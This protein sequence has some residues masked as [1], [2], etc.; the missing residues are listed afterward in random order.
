VH[1]DKAM[2]PFDKTDKRINDKDRVG[3]SKDSL[4]NVYVSHLLDVKG[5]TIN[6][7]FAFDKAKNL[8]TYQVTWMPDSSPAQ[9]Y[10]LDENG[11][12]V[13]WD[14]TQHLT[15]SEKKKMQKPVD[16]WLAQYK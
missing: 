13:D 14:A 5:G 7:L 2:K 8:C 3:L 9:S 10:R 12:V 15:D 6:L 1:Y 4:G 16:G 11:N